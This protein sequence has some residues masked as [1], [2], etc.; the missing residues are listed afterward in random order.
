MWT[1]GLLVATFICLLV[2]RFVTLLW[3]RRRFPPGPIPIP[4]IGS[5]WRVGWKIRQDTLMKL[6][7]S[8]GDVFTL[9]IGHFPVVVLTGFKNVKEGLM[10]NYERLSGRPMMPFFKL[11]GNKNG[12]MFA[13]GKTWKDQKHFGQATIQTLV[14]MQKDL[15]HQI[16]EEANLLVKTFARENGQPLDPSLA[17]MRSASKVICTAAFGH[18]APIEDEAL[19]KLTEHIS[20]V[21]KFR[22]SFGEMIYN[23]FPLLMQ[24]IPG[25]HKTVFSSC[26]FIRSFIK[27]E[28]EN[29]KKKVVADREPQNFIDFYLAQINREKVDSSTTFNED[30]LIQVIADLF[31]AGTETI[32]VTLSWGLLFMV[33]HPD[34]QEKV[35]KE[36]QSTLDPSKLI[37]YDDRKKLHY[38]N[39]VI[40]EI[41]RFS[42]IVLFGLPRLC[43]QDLN[44]F[45]HFIPKD[46]LVVADLCSVLLDP[47]QWET[48]EQFNPNHFLDKHGKYTA[49]EEFYTYGTGCRACLGKQL[50]QSELFIFFTC[51]MK[52]FTFRWPE[53]VKET[54][55]QPIMGP[56]VQPSPFK[57]CAVP[58]QAA[59]RQ[60]P[61]KDNS[62]NA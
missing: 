53:G 21:T 33:T 39:A 55:V 34:I 35:Q 16:N 56:V 13:N 22:G 51:L 27:K 25:P 40:H 10:D 19:C 60:R 15:Q 48:P 41:Q 46:T 12:V 18:D 58:H 8:Y 24:H 57:I 32:A 6:A 14:Q 52:A 59:V 28:V 29:H 54:D 1:S 11:L 36:L 45:G 50:A 47:K 42:N 4:F 9:W 3:A 37:S 7:K 17:L 5:L 30:N 61:T 2:V 31:A 43:I 38:T 26:E 44:I 62:K 20:T 23:F 49:R